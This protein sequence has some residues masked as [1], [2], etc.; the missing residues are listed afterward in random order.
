[1]KQEDI[2]RM[3]T[4]FETVGYDVEPAD[5]MTD[6]DAA[7][8]PD[9]EE[10]TRRYAGVAYFEPEGRVLLCRRRP[11]AI[12]SPGVWAF[13]GGA[14]EADE[15]AEEAAVREMREETKRDITDLEQIHAEQQPG[16]VH[17]TT[18]AV[19]GEKFA[20]KLCAEHTAFIWADPDDLP[21]DTHPG[22]TVALAQKD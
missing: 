15:T 3:N 14:I 12:A 9:D 8:D 20:P 22:V 11:D 13:P 1:M 4:F 19:H 6:P 7:A 17:F 2:D 18:F 21:E 5:H 10:Q 16:G